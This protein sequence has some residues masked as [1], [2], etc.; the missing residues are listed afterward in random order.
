VITKIKSIVMPGG[1]ISYETMVR[2]I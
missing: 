1:N 2:E